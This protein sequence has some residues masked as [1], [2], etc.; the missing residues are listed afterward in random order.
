MTM[1]VPRMSAGIEVGR[2]LDAVEAHVQHLAQGADQQRFAETRHALQ[3]HMAAAENG[4]QS[5]LDNVVVADD[6]LADF[7]AQ[8]LRR[9]GETIQF[10][11]RC[12]CGAAIRT[13]WYFKAAK[14]QDITS[15]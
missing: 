8:A 6:D 12:S 7:G 4:G 9:P 3:Q 5:A 14:W 1:L 10:A 2:E 11:L 15:L 13:G